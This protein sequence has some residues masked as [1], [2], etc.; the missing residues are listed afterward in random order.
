MRVNEKLVDL[1]ALEEQW[2]DHQRIPVVTALLEVRGGYEIVTY[3][4]RTHGR[5]EVICECS[6]YEE[7]E[8]AWNQIRGL[9]NF[10]EEFVIKYEKDE[11][12]EEDSFPGR[13]FY[14][15]L[16]ILSLTVG[17]AAIVSGFIGPI[18]GMLSLIAWFVAW[19]FAAAY[20]EA[21]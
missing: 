1:L 9:E 3:P 8:E 11:E 15:W 18:W 7:A 10:S 5:R 20:L 16:I 4:P 17:W 13:R 12:F 6:T 14:G 21:S 19:V 2:D